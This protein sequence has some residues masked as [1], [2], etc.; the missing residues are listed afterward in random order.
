MFLF[1]VVVTVRATS[2]KS[3][4]YSLTIIDDKCCVFGK[5]EHYPYPPNNLIHICSSNPY[6][7][8]SSHIMYFP[9]HDIISKVMIFPDPEN[10]SLPSKF[11]LLTS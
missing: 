3:G 6:V 11:L 5:G 9:A 4:F 7:I 8:P 1:I 10:L 2:F